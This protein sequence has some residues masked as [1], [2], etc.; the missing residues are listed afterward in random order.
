MNT[1]GRLHRARI[2]SRGKGLEIAWDGGTRTALGDLRTLDGV[3]LET[4][5]ADPS[6]A[7]LLRIGTFLW[8]RLGPPTSVAAAP[9]LRIESDDV[10]VL[11]LPWELLA[12]GGLRLVLQEGAGVALDCPGREA[13]RPAVPLGSH[14]RIVATPP[15]FRETEADWSSAGPAAG[16]TSPRITL[17]ATLADIRQEAPDADALVLR[18][19]GEPQGNQL[20]LADGG[21]ISGPDLL[22]ALRALPPRLVVIE[23]PE[24]PGDATRRLAHDLLRQGRAV[25]LV[26]AVV[27]G[28]AT[29]PSKGRTPER[30]QSGSASRRLVGLVVE[31]RKVSEAAAVFGREDHREPA[32][33]PVVYGEGGPGRLPDGGAP[34][35]LGA[36]P[37]WRVRLDRTK[38]VDAINSAV[39]ALAEMGERGVIA[40]WWGNPNQEVGRLHGRLQ[41]HFTHPVSAA[42][43]RFA[44]TPL[45]LQW[46]LPQTPQAA[47]FARMYRQALTGEGDATPETVA[48]G[49]RRRL[50]TLDRSAAPL[51][52][53]DHGVIGED[54]VADTGNGGRALQRYLDWWLQE[55]LSHVP[56]DVTV[57]LGLAFELEDAGWLVELGGHA[58][59]PGWLAP[60]RPLFLPVLE[61]VQPRDVDAVLA[62]ARTIE[63]E[64]ERREVARAIHHFTGGRY[65]EAIHAIEG[66]VFDARPWLAY[67]DRTLKGAR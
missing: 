54:A 11:S 17:A 39:G 47:D 52:Y 57:M 13:E 37:Y 46:A 32:T 65:A 18:L 48:V 14:P 66:A 36:D 41:W 27:L 2:T 1:P 15:R 29:G 45:P 55:V 51:L 28:S 23:I 34:G 25:V 40:A 19:A 61:D 20:L 8:A 9:R 16:S 50:D 38:Q 62:R 67:A 22:A 24:I 33:W 4:L 53:F 6:E 35:G 58:D 30:D 5:R 21:S 10:D 7:N 44:W 42:S 56:T 59:D 49:L 63:N 12:E 64:K 31:G 43:R 3:P 26:S 60:M